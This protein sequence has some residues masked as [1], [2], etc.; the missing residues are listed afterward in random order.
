[1]KSAITGQKK[2]SEDLDGKLKH[3]AVKCCPYTENLNAGGG[4]S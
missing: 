2:S 1:M 3:L 4:T